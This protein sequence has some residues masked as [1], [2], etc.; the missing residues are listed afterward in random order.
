MVFNNSELLKKLNIKHFRSLESTS[1]YLKQEAELGAD[2]C[3]VITADIQSGGRGRMG[4]SFLSPEGGLYMSILLR[5]SEDLGGIKACNGVHITALAAV[6]VKEAIKN[7]TGIDTYIK[8]VNDL[9]LGGKKV[10]GILA[11]GVLDEQGGF[12]YVVLGI[13]I[14]IIGD[15]VGTELKD[16]ATSLY[17]ALDKKALTELKNRLCDEILRIFL[18]RYELE[19]ESGSFFDDYKSSLFIIGKGVEVISGDLS[20]NATVID[21]NRDFT[22]LVRLDDGSELS[23]N[24]GEVRLRVQNEKS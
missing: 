24:S 22:L 21:L 23:L 18:N 10:C 17:K 9:Y 12:E 13:G 14:N 5:P 19:L 1:T 20:K 2:S 3:T 16:T 6:A 8:W 7:V 4:R 11:E 15:F